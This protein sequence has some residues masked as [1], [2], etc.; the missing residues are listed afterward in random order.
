M[1]KKTEE[2]IV[3]KLEIL[4]SSSSVKA[5][6]QYSSVHIELSTATES[7]WM[8]FIL[9]NNVYFLRF[10]CVLCKTH[11]YW[12]P[13]K[14]IM[15]MASRGR[16]LRCKIPAVCWC[17]K[18]SVMIVK[19]KQNEQVIVAERTLCMLLIVAIKTT[20]YRHV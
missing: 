3:T 13:N 17:L 9:L 1:K 20:H 16:N 4:C 7:I 11:K 15:L 12:E 2:K 14:Y 19:Y 18:E 8:S 5:V 6:H 10:F